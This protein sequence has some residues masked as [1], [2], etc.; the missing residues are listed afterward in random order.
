MHL[1]YLQLQ[2]RLHIVIVQLRCII[3]K[4]SA[5]KNDSDHLWLYR[6]LSSNLCSGHTHEMVQWF[7]IASRIVRAKQSTSKL[8][9]LP[10]QQ[11]HLPT[12]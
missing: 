9:Q 12:K 6:Q 4:L 10:E 2:W 1:A 7:V 11:L 8:Q 3:A 5:A